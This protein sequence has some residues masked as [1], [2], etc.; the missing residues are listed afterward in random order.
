MTTGEKIRERREAAGLTQKQLDAKLA[1]PLG[2]SY[3]SHLEH[4][5]TSPTTRTLKKIAAAL[6]CEAADLM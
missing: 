1:K 4:D 3:I 2:Q 5:G 6:G